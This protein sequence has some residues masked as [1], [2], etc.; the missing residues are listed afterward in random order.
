[1]TRA[2]PAHAAGFTLVEMV[3]VLLVLGIAAG[4][5][6]P[7]LSAD[8][9][10][11][12]REAARLLAADLDYA[13]VESIAHADAPRLVVFDAAEG[14]Y[15]IATAA[16]P[17]TPVDDPIGVGGYVTAFGNGR[18]GALGGVGI[19]ELGVAGDTAASGD[20]LGFGIYGQLDQPTPATIALTCGPLSITL[21][22]DPTSGQAAIGELE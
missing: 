16:A 7:M 10:T 12:L 17:Q 11:K 18:A 9:A 1:M 6:V 21:T 5:A 13:R 20:R 14:R 2:A 4:L 19:G 8:E 15:W 22:L 3:I